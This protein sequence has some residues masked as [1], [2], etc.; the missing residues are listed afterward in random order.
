MQDLTSRSFAAFSVKRC[1]RAISR[2][3]SL[4]FP[5]S[6]GIV[7]PT[8]HSFGVKSHRIR[9]AKHNKLPAVG[10]QRK[11]C[12]ISVAGGDRHILPEAESVEL[13]DPIVVTGFGASWIAQALQ[14]RPWE[15]IERPAFR[16]LLA[17]RIWP[18]ERS[19]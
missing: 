15:L 19:F 8:V 12:V 14:L 1:S 4:S 18:A 16:A 11:K 13:I 10:Q 9:D 2:P 7:D 17:C 3:E 5:A 6:P